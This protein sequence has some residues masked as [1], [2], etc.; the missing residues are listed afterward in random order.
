MASNTGSVIIDFVTRY[1]ELHIVLK[2]CPP[3]SMYR[4][5]PLNAILLA[6]FASYYSRGFDTLLYESL[7]LNYM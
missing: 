6:P 5:Q 1:D 7:D 2:I 3:H 4:L